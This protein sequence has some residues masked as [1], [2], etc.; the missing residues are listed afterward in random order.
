MAP[1]ILLH[2]GLHKTGSSSVQAALRAHAPHLAPD[3]QILLAEGRAARK[4]QEAARLMSRGPDLAR[5][6]LFRRLFSLWLAEIDLSEGQGLVVSCEDLAGHMPGHPGITAY[7]AAPRLAVVALRALRDRWPEAEIWLVYGTRAPEA[8]LRSVYWQQ[9]RHPHLTDDYDSFASALRGASDFTALL[10]RIGQETGQ[11]VIAAPLER[12][13]PRRLGPVEALY[14]LMGL[15][16]DRR[17]ALS[18]VPRANAGGSPDLAARLVALNRQGLPP[19]ALA[20]AKQA[21]LQGDA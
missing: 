2:G 8:W 18:P 5:R 21:L 6:R 17:A 12:H 15:P 11:P 4:M 3:W 16:E 10:A 14:D 13:G 1:R 20:M 9:A 19:E 7:E